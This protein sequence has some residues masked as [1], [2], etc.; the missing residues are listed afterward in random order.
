MT[1]LSKWATALWIIG[2]GGS[3]LSSLGL[4]VAASQ[5]QVL[6]LIMVVVLFIGL[7]ASLFCLRNAANLNKAD[8]MLGEIFRRCP[9]CFGSII[10]DI[11]LGRI[12]DRVL[13]RDCNAQWELILSLSCRVSRLSIRDYGNALSAEERS[14]VPDTETPERWYEWA[15]ERFRRMRPFSPPPLASQGQTLFCRFCGHRNLPDAKFCSACGRE[16]SGDPK[17]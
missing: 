11:K 4:L 5:L 1:P 3:A 16:L 7:L 2:I 13:C 15:K 8:T 9:L 10:W 12:E 17:S 6:D 14:L